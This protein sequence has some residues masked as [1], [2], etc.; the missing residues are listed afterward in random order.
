MKKLFLLF[1]T[2]TLLVGVQACKGKEEATEE[3]TEAVATE[4]VDTTA[5]AATVDTAAAA[6][7][8]PAA[9]AAAPAAK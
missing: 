5:A 4:T 7:A 3:T 2:V 1:A 6:A 9:E 8:A